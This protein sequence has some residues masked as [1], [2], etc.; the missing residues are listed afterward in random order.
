MTLS[1]SHRWNRDAW[2]AILLGL[3]T[4]L[5]Y[6][7][8]ASFYPLTENLLHG[9]TAE[10]LLT[11]GTFSLSAKQ[12]PYALFWSWNT[13]HG[14]AYPVQID[15]VDP[16]LEELLDS[17]ELTVDREPRALS[18]LLANPVENDYIS[19]FMPGTAI[20]LIPF[21]VATRMWFGSESLEIYTLY[22]VSKLLSSILVAASA[23]VL[24]LSIRQLGASQF[25]A[26][27]LSAAY[28][29]GTCVW[30]ISSQ[31]LWQHAPNEF[32]L[33]L[34]VY[35]L[36]RQNRRTRDVLFAALAFSFA[37]W[38]RPTSAFFALAGLFSLSKP[39]ERWVYLAAGTPWAVLL[40]LYNFVQFE[41]P[42]TFGE[43]LVVSDATFTTGSSSPWAT[44]FWEG[45]LGLLISPGRGLFAYSPFL[46]FSLFGVWSIW[47]TPAYR[48]LRPWTV[49]VLLVWLVHFHYYDWWGGWGFGY[50][51]IVDTVP[52]LIIFLV[53]LVSAGMLRTALP[54][55]LFFVF[56]CWSIVV[57]AYGAWT[58]EPTA[59]N[60]RHI[61]V[62]EEPNGF[63]RNYLTHRESQIVAAE[64]QGSIRIERAN[65]DSPKYRHR[66][67]SLADNPIIFMMRHSSPLRSQVLQSMQEMRGG[68][69]HA[70]ATSY[71]SLGLARLAAGNIEEAGL[72]IAR[73]FELS[74]DHPSVQE[75]IQAFQWADRRRPSA[76]E[77]A[78]GD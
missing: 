18:A 28:A 75:A 45:A 39:A 54:A 5:I 70:L 6:L 68:Q 73:A 60:G 33:L 57:Q 29:F 64:V 37:T 14:Q 26:F 9:R 20:T 16:Y 24:F 52:L 78:I 25:A 76:H 58:F 22:W 49:A 66:L 71:A 15:A 13:P 31:S 50:R 32:Y 61:Y 35:F 51:P 42:F 2:L 40:L 3:V 1:I 56:L 27:L 30:T 44:P 77:E 46:I 55:T 38:V 11:K 43:A 36:L 41:N 19:A 34:G 67:W 23:S 48:F 8:N 53:P 69:Q 12:V 65:I 72:E 63:E 74:A 7:G 62:V 21:M 17:G 47:R 4:L 10:S 59:W